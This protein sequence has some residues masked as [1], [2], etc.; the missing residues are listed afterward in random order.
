VRKGDGYAEKALT[1]KILEHGRACDAETNRD[2][3][4]P[5]RQDWISESD[6]C[7]SV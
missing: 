4:I 7:R 1:P 2:R 3:L 6:E 5:C